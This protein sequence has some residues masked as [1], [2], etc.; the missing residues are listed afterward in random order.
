ME[1]Q[2]EKVESVILVKCRRFQYRVTYFDFGD[3]ASLPS[4]H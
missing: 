3:K 4:I 1:Q 2:K